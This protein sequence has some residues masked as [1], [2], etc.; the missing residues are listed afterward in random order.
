MKMNKIVVSL[1]AA[2]VMASPLA[3]ATNGDLM[4]AVGSQN[5]ALGG[6]GVANFVGAESAF[7]NPAMLGKSK[8]SEVVGGVALFKP[9]VTNT[10]FTGTTPADSS[11]DHNYI[12]D[13]SY[14]NRTSDN[15]T[16]GVAM[17]GIAGMGVDYT[18][19]SASY[20]KAKTEMMLLKVVP[21]IAYNKDNFGLGVSPIIQ[22]GSLLMSYDATPFGGILYNSTSKADTDTNVGYSVGGYVDITTGLTLAEAYNSQIL[23]KY[24]NQIAGA[25]AGFGQTFTNELAQPAEMKAGVAYKFASH[26]TVTADYKSIKWADAPGYKD[27]GWK[28]QTVIALGGKY[29]SEGYWLG[30]GYNKADNPIVPYANTAPAHTTDGKNG[31][32]NMFNNLFFPATVKS[33]YTFGGGVAMSKNLDFEGSVMVAP[34]VTT[35]VDITDATYHPIGNPTPTPGS[36]S[37]TTTHSQ[38]SY[39]V[40]L[41]Y[42]Y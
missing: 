3:H 19:A 15:W 41:R 42:K 17:A 26:Y 18:G 38:R 2:G 20:F 34:E 4:M 8:G 5:S 32:S 40:S 37:N 23:M 11:A 13:I 7:P 10:G 25:G 22:Y 12:P 35:V 1:I 28:N 21:T 36:L 30:L 16:I 24:G 14:S 27:F 9:T 31:Y 29:A 33:A 39:T 6:S